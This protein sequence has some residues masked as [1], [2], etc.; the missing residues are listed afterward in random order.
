VPLW[1]ENPRPGKTKNFRVRGT[2]LGTAVDR[3]AETDSRRTA[4]KVM[5]LWKRQIE[6]G[7]YRDPKVG[8]VTPPAIAATTFLAAAVAYMKAGGD[9]KRLEPIIEMTG[10]HALRDVPIEEIDQVLIDNAAAALFPGAGAPTLNR[11]FYTPV[12]AVLRRADPRRP[13]I[14]RPKGWRGSRSTA[15]LEPAQLFTVLDEAEKIDREFAIWLESLPYTGLRLRE[16]LR[17]CIR[18]LNLGRQTLYLGRTKTGEPR[19][20]YL[21]MHVVVAFAN[22]PRGLDRDPDDRIFRFH[23][24]GHLYDMLHDALRCAGATKPRR[25]NGFHLFCHTYGTWMHRYG[26]LDS[27]GLTETGRWS[28]PSS[29]HR[30]VHLEVSEEARRADLLPIPKRRA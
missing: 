6:R 23:P 10:G 28:D 1:I 9:A 19:M 30:Y 2:Y 11:E 22:H 7:E 25:Q 27:Y 13:A 24:G 3:S 17:P 16:S 29:A 21:P 20:A 4:N 15:W 14:N 12:S 8:A 18:D 26:G 5:Q